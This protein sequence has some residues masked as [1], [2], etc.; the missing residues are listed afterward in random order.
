VA[1][2]GLGAKGLRLDK[3]GD[4]SRVFADAIAAG[5]KGT[6]VLVNAHLAKTD[7]RKGSISM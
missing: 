4:A 5:R 1:A 3:P 7:F 6:P 2:E